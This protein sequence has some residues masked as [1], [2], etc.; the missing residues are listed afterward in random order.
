MVLKMFTSIIEQLEKTPGVIKARINKSIG[1]VLLYPYQSKIYFENGECGVL[2][3]Y[4][5]GYTQSIEDFG[6]SSGTINPIKVGHYCQIESHAKI[7]LGGEHSN[8]AILN[9]SYELLPD[10]KSMIESRGGKIEP[11]FSKGMIDIRSNVVISTG[12]TILSGVTIGEGAVIAAGAIVTKNV[13]PFAIVGGNPARVIK[14]RFD[15]QTIENLLKIRWWD[16][17]FSFWV[18]N[19]EAIQKLYLP[20][21]Q[22]KFLNLDPSVYYQSH[23]YFVLKA[24]KQENTVVGLNILGIETNGQFI[25]TKDCPLEIKF[26]INQ[27]SAANGSEVYLIKD[28]FK[29]AGLI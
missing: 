26:F 3:R 20:E 17:N 28:V 13:P 9:I 1:K 22:E 23:N 18:N 16:F 29:F 14:Y 4:S 2:G 27:M 21:V 24:Q 10:I 7:L 8:N 12:A 5:M 11:I 6:H 25:A 15:E 19:F